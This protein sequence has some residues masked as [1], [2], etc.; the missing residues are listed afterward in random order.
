MSGTVRTVNIFRPVE[1]NFPAEC[2]NVGVIH[3]GEA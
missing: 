3:F 1:P 2:Y